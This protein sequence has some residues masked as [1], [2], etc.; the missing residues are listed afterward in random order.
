MSQDHLPQPFCTEC[1]HLEQVAQG[2][3]Q[4]SSQKSLVL[5]CLLSPINYLYTFIA[6]SLGFHTVISL[7]YLLKKNKH[8]PTKEIQPKNI[9]FL[10]KSWCLYFVLFPF[11]SQ[12]LAPFPARILLERPF[13]ITFSCP[14]SSRTLLKYIV[15]LMVSYVPNHQKHVI[16][17]ASFTNL[18]FQM[19]LHIR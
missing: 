14:S 3:V 10:I 12:P 15:F 13:Q 7:Q 8:F 18:N 4:L 2:H 19:A 9:D 6:M 17:S 5:S 16:F 11:P 1:G